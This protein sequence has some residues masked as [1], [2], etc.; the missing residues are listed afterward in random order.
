MINPAPAP[1]GVLDPQQPW[2]PT[3][4][5]SDRSWDILKA[6]LTGQRMPDGTQYETW[7]HLTS[8]DA[9]RLI[10]N[11]KKYGKYPQVNQT[12]GQGGYEH[13]LAYQN[14]LVEEF[15]EKPFRDETNKKIEDAETESRLKE[16]QEQKKQKPKEEEAE[17]KQSVETSLK[18]DEQDEKETIKEV[19]KLTDEVDSDSK[20]EVKKE[21]P[22]EQKDTSIDALKESLDNIKGSISSQVAILNQTNNATNIISSNVSSLK[23]IFSAQL[24]QAQEK[25]EKQKSVAEEISLEQ[26]ANVVSGKSQLATS[27]FQKPKDKNKSS[28]ILNT[29]VNLFSKGLGGGTKKLAGGGF[30]NTPFPATTSFGD[31]GISM[32]PSTGLPGTVSYA[33][34]VIK[35]GLYDNPTRGQ[36]LPGE[37]VIPLN[38]NYGKDILGV[39]KMGGQDVMQ[40]PF[41]DVMQQ[42]IKAIGMS[43]VAIAGQFIRSLGAL[44][45]F[46]A[47]YI[48]SMIKPM[49]SVLGVSFSVI[50]ALLG[51][52]AYAA[53]TDAKRQTDIFSEIWSSLMKR[54]GF[55]FGM[56]TEEDKK[57]KSNPAGFEEATGGDWAKKD[58]EFVAAVNDAAR[59][60]GVPAKYLFAIM[61][62]ETGGTMDPKARNPD[63]GATGLIQFL[64]PESVGTS[65]A[66]LRNM[67]RAEQMKYVVAYFKK[68]GVKGPATG[69]DL[70]GAVFLPSYASHAPQ[71][72]VLTSIG[73]AAY[74][75][76]KGLDANNDGKITKED[77]QKK[78]DER[79]S[80]YTK[81][82][83]ELGSNT[84]QGKALDAFTLTGPTSGY[85]V[86]GVGTM[87]GKEALIQHEKGFTILPI[88]NRKFSMEKDPLK[89]I[90]RWNQLL[91]GRS[92][93]N[94][95]KYE[96]G[97]IISY[98][99]KF[100]NGLSG[101]TPKGLRGANLKRIMHGTAE[102]IPEL[103]RA[104]GFRGQTGML[105][106]GVYGSMKGWVADTY[107]GAGKWK[108][109]LPGQGPRLDMLV[110][111]ASKTFRGATVVSERQANR[112]LRIAEG[113]LSGKY[114]GAKAKS[115]LPLLEKAT[116]TMAEAALTTAGGL[117]KLAGR[118]LPILDAP[119]INDM[120]FPESVGESEPQM[121]PNGFVNAPVR[122]QSIASGKVSKKPQ[123]ITLPSTGGMG[124]STVV[125]EQ[126]QPVDMYKYAKPKSIT[127]HSVME[128]INAQ[129]FQ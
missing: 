31:G 43:I 111:E 48:K 40:Q 91:N 103:I 101:N 79:A 87:H 2:W 55:V 3:A 54:F 114:T 106:K 126:S 61:D 95:G 84:S 32:Y 52:P 64:Y 74:K 26:D 57:P 13:L 85:D 8:S 69:G 46:F 83:S 113:I 68:W 62:V 50:D 49:A 45:G 1:E 65:F 44:G 80:K 121:G 51:G 34:G 119:L 105:G 118:A 98:L 82:S 28:G 93:N 47:P 76:N 11:I 88:E 124:N 104:N 120:L 14:W 39:R 108:G 30:L 97:G 6:K 10:A 36:L 81:L 58:P 27:T 125:R 94:T 38:R 70:Y 96:T 102:G 67:T 63:S 66:E 21:E 123:I 23:D 89:T 86:P 22:E 59:E 117:G 33:K 41:A 37:A 19:T 9:D 127:H 110:P 90:S 35:P 115:L 16:I 24:K 53:T 78:L 4:N 77:L 107:R 7:V 17:E 25:I 15:L 100:I 99:S 92:D 75:G 72:K 20:E 129:R 128:R 71:D 60:L 42:P 109:I 73:D 5:M 116:P 29:A 12:G 112:G 18:N 56:E 122:K